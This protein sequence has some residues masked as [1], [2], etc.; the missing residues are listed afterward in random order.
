MPRNIKR[1]LLILVLFLIIASPVIAAS[2]D[3]FDEATKYIDK[4]C[5]KPNVKNQ[6]SVLCYLFEKSNEQQ[7]KIDEFEQR[8][9]DLE[10]ALATPSPSPSPTI[11]Y[12]ISDGTWKFSDSEE[13]GW[14]NSGFDD[15]SWIFV[16]APSMGQCGPNPVGGGITENG[17]QNISVSDPNWAGATGYFRKTFNLSALPTSASIRALY[18][19]DGDVY[20][21]GNLIISN[22]DG[23][24]AGIDQETIDPSTFNIGT[25]VLAVAVDDAAGGCQWLQAELTLQL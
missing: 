23:F 3:F 12:I 10:N 2:S 16:E 13:A 7:N 24:I 20:L 6:N 19:D 22:H 11:S 18:D 14:L 4:T 5:T 25:N 9:Q 1:G 21:N 15:S 8:I 17:V